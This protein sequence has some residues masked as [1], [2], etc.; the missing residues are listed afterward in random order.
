MIFGFPWYIGPI[1]SRRIQGD[2]RATRRRDG[3]VPLRVGRPAM[4]CPDPVTGCLEA[5]ET[6]KAAPVMGR[7]TT[8][9]P[10]DRTRLKVG[11]RRSERDPHLSRGRYYTWPVGLVSTP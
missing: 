9:V 1:W 3:Q 5:V 2:N 4:I 10:L 8:P 11:A 6:K 7:R